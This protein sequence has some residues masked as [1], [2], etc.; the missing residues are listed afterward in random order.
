MSIYDEWQDFA[1]SND[2]QLRVLTKYIGRL[3]NRTMIDN[4]IVDYMAY[5]PFAE[6]ESEWVCSAFPNYSYGDSL[7]EM[8]VEKCFD[9]ITLKDVTDLGSEQI[10]TLIT[11]AF[12]DDHFDN[13]AIME[14]FRSGAML[15]W[16]KRLKDI[17]WKK[18]PRSI[19]E[20]EL[21]LGGYGGYDTYRVLLTD[22]KA[23]LSMN[24]LNYGDPEASTDEK[25]NIVAIR[26]VLDELHFEY[27]LTDY[28]QEGELRICDGEQWSLTV[29]YDD[30]TQ[31]VIGG[32][33]TYPE[34]WKALLEFFGI[35]Y[36]D[37]NDDE[38]KRQPD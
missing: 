19:T 26:R 8:G 25:E 2:E 36:D 16:L 6:F 28:L 18:H 30:S 1:P 33:N 27:W 35:D 22:E 5:F 34:N 3:S 7:A 17:D 23:I 14:Y 32:D 38:D 29:K 10:F 24:I 13:G 12:R 15:K 21:Q 20:V 9:S 31:L 4:H 37:D 11:A